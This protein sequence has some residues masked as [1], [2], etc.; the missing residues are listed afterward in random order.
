MQ[1]VHKQINLIG[2]KWH[3]KK[4]IFTQTY[5]HIAVTL[6]NCFSVFSYKTQQLWVH[7]GSHITFFSTEERFKKHGYIA[8][9]D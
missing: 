2:K 9:K 4:H 3:R 8:L 6:Q 1:Q 5:S 7:C